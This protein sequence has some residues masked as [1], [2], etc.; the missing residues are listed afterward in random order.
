MT[1]DKEWEEALETAF[2]GWTDEGNLGENYKGAGEIF[3]KT[4]LENGHDVSAYLALSAFIDE[5][6][7][8]IMESL[9]FKTEPSNQAK[10]ELRRINARTK[11]DLLN[12]TGILERDT[13]NR[14]RHFWK[15]RNKLAHQASKHVYSESEAQRY[16]DAFREGI[17]G[18]RE[19]VDLSPGTKSADELLDY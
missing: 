17:R 5:L 16:K 8:D 18:Y 14:I 12:L 11:A 2:M 4:L 3:I 19:L 7:G 6:L 15:H 10:N 9:L 13:K 1:L